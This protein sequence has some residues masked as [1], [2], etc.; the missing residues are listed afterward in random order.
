M[1]PVRRLAFAACA[2]ALACGGAHAAGIDAYSPRPHDGHAVTV[3]AG[4]D[5]GAA[6]DRCLNRCRANRERCEPTNVAK[7]VCADA[8]RQCAHICSSYAR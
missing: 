5:I 6:L 4:N 7:G 3:L 2:M 1:L 8:F